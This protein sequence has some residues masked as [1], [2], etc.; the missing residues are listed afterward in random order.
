MEIKLY[1]SATDPAELKEALAGLAS[2]SN[3]AV[4]P[5]P[6]PEKAK[7][8]T[9]A[10]NKPEK[11]QDE[12][13]KSVEPESKPDE[14]PA[15]DSPSTEN[16]PSVVELRAKAQEKASSPEGKKAIKALLDKFGS[17]SISDVPEDKRA[18][19]YRELEEL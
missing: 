1:I 16:A 11:S 18:A 5:Q 12:S 13:E 17:K 19:F 10:T 9:R 6:E 4:A 8:N 3:G 2:I 7:R 15:P 14:T